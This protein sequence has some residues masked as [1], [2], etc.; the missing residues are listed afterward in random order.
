MSL[1]RCA[2]EERPDPVA[3]LAWLLEAPGG[4]AHLVVT[5]AKGAGL[6]A[7][8]RM[9][10]EAMEARCLDALGDLEI[11]RAVFLHAEGIVPLHAPVAVVGAAADHRKEVFEASDRLMEA[12][13]GVAERRDR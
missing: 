13:E 9:E 1:V 7:A 5:R 10:L 3:L 2:F 12:L 4:A 6:E 8:A 11:H